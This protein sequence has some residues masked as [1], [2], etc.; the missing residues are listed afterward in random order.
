MAFNNTRYKQHDNKI[1]I[2]IRKILIYYSKH[3][4]NMNKRKLFVSIE[5]IK[6]ISYCTYKQ[7]KAQSYNKINI[8]KNIKKTDTY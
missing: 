1:A 5:K 7:T 4:F 8:N 6:V 2:S 3:A